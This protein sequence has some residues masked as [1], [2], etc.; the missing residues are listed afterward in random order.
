MKEIIYRE[1]AGK[2]I[3]NVTPHPITFGTDDGGTIT[4]PCSG[5]IVNAVTIER[6]IDDE[7]V[8]TEFAKS[9]EDVKQVAR[10][11]KWYESKDEWDGDIFGDGRKPLRIVGSFI[12][13]NAY[14]GVICGMVPLKEFERVPPDQK[15]MD[16]HKFNIA[17]KYGL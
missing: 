7:L 15:R 9:E 5:I 13:M 4:V 8:T 16:P 17:L 12:A 14:P 10:I 11:K 1:I 2:I 6:R 3:V